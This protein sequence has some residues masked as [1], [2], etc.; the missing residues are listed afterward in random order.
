MLCI[1]VVYSI[2]LLSNINCMI[3]HNW[4]ICSPAE[5][6]LVSFQTGAIINE[7]AVNILIQAFM[8]VGQVM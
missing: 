6:H 5:G 4:F 1:S 3:K 8:W 2:L 7:T